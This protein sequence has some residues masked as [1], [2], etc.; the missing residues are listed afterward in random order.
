MPCYRQTYSKGKAVCEKVKSSQEKKMA[1]VSGDSADMKVPTGVLVGLTMVTAGAFGNI[2]DSLFYGLIFS[3]SESG[4]V[5][6]FGGGYAPF[7]FG[8]VVDMFYFPLIDTT[9]PSWFPF[10]GGHPF[11][12]FEPVLISPTAA[13][14][15][16]LFILYCSNTAFFHL[17]TR[18]SEK[19]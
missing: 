5:A 17:R 10:V 2:L 4:I 12:F 18:K 11:R 15:W 7:L 1:A 16:A 14:L 19:L 6:S 9:F 13:L 3:A 8:K